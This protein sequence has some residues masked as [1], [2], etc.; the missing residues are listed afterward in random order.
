MRLSDLAGEIGGRPAGE[1]IELTG[2]AGIEEARAGD[3][4]LIRD[5][6]ALEGG[7]ESRASAFIVPP[8]LEEMIDRPCLVSDNPMLS[9]VRALEVFYRKD[10]PRLGVLPG[11]H[12]EDGV[13]VGQDVT[14]YP[15]A[16]ISR[17]VRLGQRVTIYPGAFIGEGSEIG[18]DTIIHPGVV[19]REGVRIGRRVII[20][21][22]A[23]IGADG[24][25]Y[26]PDEGRHRK[27]P[28]VGG[29]VIGDDVEIGACTCID[30]ATT[31]NTVIGEG[32][33]VDNLAQIAHN[34]TIGKHSII[35]SLV[36]IAGSVRIGDHVT[37]AGQVGV[38]DH[39]EIESNTV[40]GAMSGVMGKLTSGVYL[41][42][43]ARPHREYLRLQGLFARL[44]DLFRDLREL[45]EEMERLRETCRTEENNNQ[46]G[47]KND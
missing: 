43:P 39:A 10:L 38:A 3:I 19:I 36:G 42:A 29:V 40:V 26:I 28:Q 14:V 11:A 46:P 41:G 37:L 25:G 5:K 16:Y 24:F 6:K 9:F 1:D 18:D 4:T 23:V 32:T 34:V 7:L 13:S 2:V 8:A 45:K 47:G 31:G 20:H 35:V 15:F 27:I 33:K 17:G 44:P 21:P 22:N 30:R 12:L